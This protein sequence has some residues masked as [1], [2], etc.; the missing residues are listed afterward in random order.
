MGPARRY[1]SRPIDHR[2]RLYTARAMHF[3]RWPIA[4]RCFQQKTNRCRCLYRN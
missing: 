4:V 3:C 2:C 1:P